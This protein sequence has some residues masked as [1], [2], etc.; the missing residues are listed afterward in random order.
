MGYKYSSAAFMICLIIMLPVYS[1]YVRADI[2]A[3]KTYDEN[4]IEGF[5]KT[6]GDLTV[7]AYASVVNDYDIN[8]SQV[9][10]ENTRF[11]ECL[12]PDPERRFQC[13][14]TIPTSGFTLD[15][16]SHT[17]LVKLYSDSEALVDTES[18]T[19]TFDD[20]NPII[21]SFTAPILVGKG[22]FDV[23][24]NVR[25]PTNSD[26]G[27][28]GIGGVRLYLNGADTPFKEL[29]LNEEL[30]QKS[31]AVT[32]QGTSLQ[33]GLNILEFEVY[34]RFS[35][36]SPRV[37]VEI[38][39]ELGDAYVDNVV[40]LDKATDDELEWFT[41]DETDII[42]IAN[43]S[44]PPINLDSV[45]AD[46]S[47]LNR[48]YSDNIDADLC[49]SYGSITECTWDPLEIE[50][51]SSVNAEFEF[52][53]EDHAGNDI[54]ISKSMQLMIDTT[55][56][57][58]NSI[59]SEY[60]GDDGINYAG[61]YNGANFVAGFAENAYMD[62]GKIFLY[63][64]DISNGDQNFAANAETCNKTSATQW[65]CYFRNIDISGFIPG[66]YQAY[67]LTNSKD[68]FDNPVSN[69]YSVDFIYDTQPPVI[70]NVTYK[71]IS[72]EEESDTRPFVQIG[73][74]L[75]ITANITEDNVLTNVTGDF[76]TIL[77]GDDAYNLPAECTNV[78]GD[79][80]SCIW[81]TDEIDIAESRYARLMIYANDGAGNR[82]THEM[83][84]Q[85]L[86]ILET[87]QTIW[88]ANTVMASPTA[89]DRQMVTFYEPFMW[90]VIELVSAEEGIVPISVTVLGCYN[91]IASAEETLDYAAFLSGD[92]EPYLYTS[93]GTLPEDAFSLYLKSTMIQAYPDNQTDVLKINC[94]ID[95]TGIRDYSIP[96]SATGEYIAMGGTIVESPP[97]NVSLDIRYFNNPIGTISDEVNDEIEDIKNSWL[98][99][100]EWI[101]MLDK[102]LKFGQM[103]CGLLMVWN[104][105]VTIFTTVKD[106]FGTTCK[107]GILSS[108][109]STANIQGQI[110]EKQKATQSDLYNMTKPY[111][112]MLN[113][114]YSNDKKTDKSSGLMSYA[115]LLTG[116]PSWRDDPNHK[117]RSAWLGNLNPNPSSSL[118][119]SVLYLCLP[120]VIYN[121]QKARAIDCVYINCLNEVE[122]GMPIQLCTSQR[123]YAY[124]KYVF[125]EIFSLIPFSYAISQIGQNVLKAISHPLEFIGFAFKMSCTVMCRNPTG[126]FCASCTIVNFMNMM[127][128]VLCD[129]G[130]GGERCETAIWDNLDVAED[131]CDMALDDGEEDEE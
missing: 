92:P 68:Y 79:E 90:H 72:G 10:L 58:V 30:C 31:G 17:F 130:I 48:Y 39:A 97:I 126:T 4:N 119:L 8:N 13:L 112:A 107:T 51:E 44:G 129:L 27:C 29:E 110:V 41:T 104:S 128:D 61:A 47:D 54:S 65:K 108:S 109:C 12:N 93:I 102:I 19:V 103:I 69:N 125:G 38:S 42:L 32:L 86:D 73:D 1:S 82:D 115:N 100:A 123:G 124:C 60:I 120:G 45:S 40:I 121:L 76:H 18:A 52:T 2:S 25:D 131:A 63:F 99:Q 75:E 70:N 34:D 24:Y 6:H 94:T 3:V 11:Q 16:P 118:L 35:Q 84:I 56:P 55:G 95:I 36:L 71:V 37:S 111:C 62:P 66:Q 127:L 7:E 59:Y 49:S 87:D 122:N 74:S 20:L 50:I 116:Q 46:F 117:D 106:I 114:Q 15:R 9:L 43:F 101:G 14:I 33:D 113:C 22:D 88:S 64:G 57:T 80:W 85:V 89:I 23:Q 98:V 91:N 81:H 83:H 21:Q 105:V 78:Q 67:I 77:Y 28:T 53:M 5:M 26:N 96:D